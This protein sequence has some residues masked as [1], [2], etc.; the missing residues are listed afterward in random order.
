MTKKAKKTE[1]IPAE[2]T[3]EET[4]PKGVDEEVAE[5]PT[6]E[7]EEIPAEPEPEPSGKVEKPA[8]SDPPA[9]GEEKEFTMKLRVKYNGKSY[10][11]GESYKLSEKAEKIMREL[12][13]I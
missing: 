8:K 5:E 6:P 2:E 1:E 10:K 9:Q 12:G 11:K 7:T 3:I 13:A 4:T